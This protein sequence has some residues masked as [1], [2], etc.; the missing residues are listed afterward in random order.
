MLNQDK[1]HLLFFSAFAFIALLGVLNVTGLFHDIWVVKDA[2]LISLHEFMCDS[3]GENY[4]FTTND[5]EGYNKQCS[6]ARIAAL[7]L[8]DA[9][10]INVPVHEFNCTSGQLLTVDLSEGASNKGMYNGCVYQGVEF[11]TELKQEPG[12]L[13]FNRFLCDEKDYFYTMSFAE[14]KFKECEYQ[15]AIGFAYRSDRD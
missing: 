8:K 9:S 15:D 2:D 13:P 6:Y 14:G 10:P 1:F 4:F 3:E 7:V 12:S 11:Y 5:Q